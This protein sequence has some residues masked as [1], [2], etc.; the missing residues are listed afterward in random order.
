LASVYALTED[1][2]TNTGTVLSAPTQFENNAVNNNGTVLVQ[3]K[4]LTVEKVADV[5]GVSTP[6]R[7][8]DLIGYTITL[9]NIGLLGLTGVALD[10]SIIPAANLVLSAGDTNNDSVLDAD[11]VWVYTATYA[12]TQNDID[13]FGA[14]DGVIDNVV[15]VTTNE[16]GP[17]TDNADVSITQAPELVVTKVVDKPTVADPTTLSYTIEVENTGNQ[18]LTNIV[19]ADTLPDGSTGT[20]VGPVADTGTV[21]VLD[22]NEIWTYKISYAVSQAEIDSGNPLVNEV[23]V[24]STETG[25]AAVTDNA[26]STITKAPALLVSKLVDITSINSPATLNYSIAIEN[27]GNV[28]LNN[29]APIDV[30]PDGSAGVLAGPVADVGTP[31]ALDVGETWEYTASYNASQIDIDAGGVLENTI[32]VTADETGD[33]IG[34][35]SAETSITSEPSLLVNKS[36]DVASM[37]AP[38]IL[39]YSITVENN[40]NVSLTDVEVVDT[41]PDG[42]AAALIGPLTD[43]GTAGALDVGESWEFTTTYTVSQLEI[44]VGDV[45]INTV[46]VTSNETG[47]VIVS[48]AAQTTLVRTPTFTLE[49]TVDLTSISTPG[50]LNYDIVVDNTG[51]TTLTGITISDTLPDGAIAT[52]TGPLADTGSVG[53]LDV[54]EIW[55]YTGEYVVTQAEID[56]GF[57]GYGGDQY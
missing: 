55:T 41:L 6:I 31:G 37:S 10:D 47:A 3:P 5:S 21:G 44:D 46:D 50:T 36:V 54:G 45:L 17:L 7:A 13:S 24:T 25:N 9:D 34:S 56:A 16:L 30:M 49:K 12:V 51:N 18:S 4:G 2:F 35:A 15:T 20:L 38:G 19:L 43:S 1:D 40:G 57:V 11:E 8:G 14:G 39:N 26:T 42:S 23:S 48:D 52:L 27:T 28:T 32:N 29:V 33:A 22:V 53:V